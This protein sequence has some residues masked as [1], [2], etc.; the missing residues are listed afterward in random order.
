MKNISFKK[1]DWDSQ[2]FGFNIYNLDINNELF[3]FDSL[4]NIILK[5][6]DLIQ[7]CIDNSIL[8]KI[9]LH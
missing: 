6:I 5:K 1:L 7:S 9:F 2:F 8:S 4:K 3:N